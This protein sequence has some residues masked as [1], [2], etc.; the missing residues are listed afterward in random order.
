M[1][2]CD[3]REICVFDLRPWFLALSSPNPWNFLNDKSNGSI[4]YCNIWFW[5]Q[6]LKMLQRYRGEMG[7]L[8]FTTSPFPLHLG[9]CYFWKCPKDGDW[10]PEEPTTNGGLELWVKP[11]WPPGGWREKLEVDSVNSHLCNEA[12]IKPQRGESSEKVWAGEHVEYKESGMA[13]LERAWKLC[14]L[15]PCASLPS[16]WSWVT[17]FY[18]KPGIL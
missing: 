9:L 7:V 12:S 1:R 16:G 2:L 5:H 6:F 3:L 13:Y 15:S 14:T 18:S 4:F 11:A 10:L 17:S 8:L